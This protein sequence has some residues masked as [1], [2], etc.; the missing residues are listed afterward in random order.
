MK[1]TF[2]EWYS[3]I[4]GANELNVA[5]IASLCFDWGM[6]GC[7]FFGCLDAYQSDM[8]AVPTAAGHQS[9]GAWFYKSCNEKVVPRAP[10]KKSKQKKPAVHTLWPVRGSSLGFTA[11]Q[12]VEI[13]FQRIKTCLFQCFFLC[14]FCGWI[15]GRYLSLDQYHTFRYADI[16]G[17]HCKMVH[18]NPISIVTWSISTKGAIL[19]W[20]K[21]RQ[22]CIQH[23]RDKGKVQAR[24][25]VC[26]RLVM[27]RLTGCLVISHPYWVFVLVFLDPKEQIS[28]TLVIEIHASS[29]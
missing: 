4:P 19:T 14:H 11:V 23:Q 7:F 3:D 29:F 17:C 25:F 26:K 10:L 13:H 22:F 18:I 20:A 12:A 6:H 5:W 27:S 1:I 8:P 15:G 28:M 24:Y 2:S 16:V 9:S 21:S